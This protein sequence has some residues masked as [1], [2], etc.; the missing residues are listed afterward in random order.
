MKK[1]GIAYKRKWGKIEDKPPQ[2][3]DNTVIKCKLDSKIK[4]EKSKR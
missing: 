1:K 4:H 3:N 2:R